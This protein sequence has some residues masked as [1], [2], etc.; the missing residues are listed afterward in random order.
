MYKL[1]F[2]TALEISD[3]S[4]LN[5]NL[6]SHKTLNMDATKCNLENLLRLDLL[7]KI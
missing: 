2:I 6:N 7:L 5:L 1:Y 3:I 4:I